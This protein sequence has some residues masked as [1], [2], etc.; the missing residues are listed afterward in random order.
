MYCQQLEN[1]YDDIIRYSRRTFT[2]CS[3]RKTKTPNG[4]TSIANEIFTAVQE[5]GEVDT[6]NEAMVE[7]F[8]WA[9]ITTTASMVGTFLGYTIL[10]PLMRYSVD[11]LSAALISYLV[12]PLSAHLIFRRLDADSRYADR[13]GDWRLRSLSLV[14]CFIQGIFNGHVIHNIYVTGQPIPVVTPAAIAYT[15]ANMPK[16]AGRNRIAQLCSSLNC[17]L[18]ANISIGAITG[19]LS[20]PYYFLTLGYCVAAGIVMQIIFKKV[21]KKTPLH[22]FQHAVTSLMIAVKG[23]FFLLFGSYAYR[24]DYGV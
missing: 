7:V 16:E 11:S 4:P 17:A 13:E 24:Y 6:P 14:F 1:R 22:T 2:E 18:T 10:A 9:S 20:P 8:A 3:T 5:K 15:F 21:H 12:L 23:L 19:H